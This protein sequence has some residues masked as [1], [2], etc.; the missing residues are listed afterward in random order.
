MKISLFSIV[1]GSEACNAR[2]PFC[3]SK[4]T[5]P[6]GITL[7]E[8][9]VN[10]RNFEKACQFAQRMNVTT[11]MITGKGEPTLFPSQIT[12]FLERLSKYEMPLVELQTNGIPLAEKEDSDALLRKWYDLGLTTV[13]ISIVHYDAE[14]NRQIYL[15][16]RKAYIDLP[17]LIARI[18]ACGLNVRLACIMVNGYIDSAEEVQKLIHF[19]HENKVEQLTFRP[20]NNPVE[21]RNKDVGDWTAQ[22]R[23]SLEQAQDIAAFLQEKGSPLMKT[24][25][26]ATVY[27]VGGQNVCITNSLTL[28]KDSEDIRQLI[29]F[30][31][32]HLAYDWQHAGAILL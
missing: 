16:Y 22:H 21:S 11:A 3:I 7:A 6:N 20:V 30:P 26:G 27:D 10:W 8:P 24:E 15:P 25:Y 29:F 14:K 31:N 13:A 23:L 28:N 1:A 5:P 2:C 18:H 12:T 32:G 9:S 17:K 4:M 19:A